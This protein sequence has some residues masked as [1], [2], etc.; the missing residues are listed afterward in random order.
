[1]KGKSGRPP[2]AA[3]RLA[4]EKQVKANQQSALQIDM[5]IEEEDDMKA[6]IDREAL[7]VARN[8]Y[9]KLFEIYDERAAL[10]F[11]SNHWLRHQIAKK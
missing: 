8:R 10:K 4:K 1:M 7:V 5:D 3:A 6:A 2:A 9:P 11:K